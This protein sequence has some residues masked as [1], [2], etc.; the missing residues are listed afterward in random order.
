M[1]DFPMDCLIGNITSIV[2]KNKTEYEVIVIVDKFYGDNSLYGKVKG[3]YI[4]FLLKDSEM[5]SFKNILTNILNYYLKEFNPEPELNFEP[6]HEN[7]E[8]SN[9]CRMKLISE[10]VVF[11]SNGDIGNKIFKDY[12]DSK[13]AGFVF[14]NLNLFK[15]LG[16]SVFNKILMTSE[17]KKDLVSQNTF[18]FLI[19]V[20]NLKKN[21]DLI[22]YALN[23]SL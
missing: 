16:E 7:M 10:G 9:F 14:I 6:N 5:I 15:G 1:K 2:R 4:S 11:H 17:L 23:V 18:N 3:D 8:I 22:K 12:G 13:F 20:G 21:F 19:P